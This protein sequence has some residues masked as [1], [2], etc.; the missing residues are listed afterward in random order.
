MAVHFHNPDSL[1]APLGFSHLVEVSDA[2]WIFIAGQVSRDAAG[3]LVGPGD[4]AR[5]VQQAFN[6][7]EL[8]LAAVGATCKDL[9]KLNYYCAA[10][11]DPASWPVIV[12]ARDQHVD[13]ER[14]PAS[15]FVVVQRLLRS[16]WLIEIE[17]VAALASRS[18]Q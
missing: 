1:P 4:F 6:N 15:T 8:A 10:S 7:L 14:P 11:V 9:V 3:Q 13:T 18:K 17:A 16:E 5:Q 12:E 2:R